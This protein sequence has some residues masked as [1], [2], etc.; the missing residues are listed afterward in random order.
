LLD[1]LDLPDRPDPLGV[2]ELVA[3]PVVVDRLPVVVER[4]RAEP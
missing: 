1:L 3:L 2:G 4:V